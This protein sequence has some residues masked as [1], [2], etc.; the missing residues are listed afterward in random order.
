MA[1]K[2]YPTNLVTCRY[3]RKKDIDRNKQIKDIDWVNPSVN[4]FYHAEC[5]KLKKEEESR[6][7]NKNLN[8]SMDDTAL[9][10]GVY[11]FLKNDL[12]IVIN[13]GAFT[14][15]WDRLIKKGRTPKGIYFAL[16][17]FYDIKKNSTDKSKGSIGIVDYI[18]EESYEYWKERDFREEGLISRIEAQAQ[19][20][21]NSS[22]IEIKV[23]PRASKK[24]KYSM[25]DD[26]DDC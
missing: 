24:N 13:Y 12:K 22:P 21:L 11:Y 25:V 7:Q 17:Y 6:K 5:Y 15:E 9:K 20:M 3:C 16:K 23:R 8:D 26:D 14:K 18:Y 1:E 4:W 19:K 10:E 2:K